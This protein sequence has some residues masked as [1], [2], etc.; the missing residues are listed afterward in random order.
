M[1]TFIAD[2]RNSHTAAV[3]TLALDDERLSARWVE[4][5]SATRTKVLALPYG[6]QSLLISRELYNSIGGFRPIAIMEDVDIARRLGRQHI[7]VFNSCAL[8]SA[9]R[10][11]RHG[12]FWRPL[13]NLC[14]LTLWFIGLP[15]DLIARIYNR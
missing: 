6:D 9:E 2:T 11:R 3:F 4:W 10:Y 14:C 15:P 8:T 13:R 5:I 12:F 7:H 1:N